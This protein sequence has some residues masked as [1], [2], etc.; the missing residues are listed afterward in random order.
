[1]QIKLLSF[2]CPGNGQRTG[3]LLDRKVVDLTN[4]YEDYLIKEMGVSPESAEKVAKETLPPSML[5]LIENGEESMVAA[6]RVTKYVGERLESGE[7]ILVSNN[8]R[9]ITYEE[10]EVKILKPIPNNYSPYNIG[11]NDK[12]YAKMMGV[13]PPEPGKTCMFMLPPRSVIGPGEPVEWPVSA[14]DVMGEVEVGVIIGK[15]AKQI[16]KAEAPDVI[17]GYTIVNDLC[18]IDIIAKGLGTGREG[19][20]GAYYIARAKGFDTFEPMGP[21]IV[22]ADQ[23]EDNRDIKAEFRVNNE[24]RAKGSTSHYRL[25]INELIEYLSEDITFYPG[26]IISSGGIGSP[27][28]E[29]GVHVKPGDIME[30]ELEGIGVLKNPV[31]GPKDLSEKQVQG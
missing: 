31:R 24:V 7:P 15:K 21:F 8:G 13:D 22:P 2:Q 30:A 11:V 29:A 3:I 27:E 10:R 23:I 4:G 6:N 20:P 1:M 19:F 14:K 17:F 26:D 5:R 9:K 18:G 16:S 12:S 28:Y 25:T